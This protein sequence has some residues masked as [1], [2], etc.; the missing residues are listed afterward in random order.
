MVK[1]IIYIMVWAWRYRRAHCMQL[2]WIELPHWLIQSKLELRL[3]NEPSFSISYQVMVKSVPPYFVRP[4]SMKTILTNNELRFCKGCIVVHDQVW[5]SIPD[6]DVE[7]LV[8]PPIKTSHAFDMKRVWRLVDH[9]TVFHGL[10]SNWNN[11]NI[12]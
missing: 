1:I 6:K 2:V 4:W 8:H 9:W 10:W 3:T 11:K 7:C 5:L 12:S